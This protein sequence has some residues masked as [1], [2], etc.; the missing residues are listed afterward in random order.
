ML[1]TFWV[2]IAAK[3]RYRSWEPGTVEVRKLKPATKAN[4]VA[5]KIS[6]EIPDAY[7]ETPELS[8]KI[9][10]PEEAVNKPV[11]TP[12]VQDNLAVLISEQ[13]GMKVHVSANNKEEKQ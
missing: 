10:V 9:T 4:E 12:E 2:K 3:K 7:F 11:I 6:V 5:V 1:S 8:A 13:L